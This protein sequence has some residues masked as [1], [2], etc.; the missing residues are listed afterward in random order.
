MIKY[1]Y[2]KF[3]ERVA[4]MKRCKFQNVAICREI[5]EREIF[6]KIF[7]IQHPPIQICDKALYKITNNAGKSFIINSLYCIEYEENRECSVTDFFT[8]MPIFLNNENFS[9]LC[10]L[11]EEECEC[12]EEEVVLEYKV[13]KIPSKKAEH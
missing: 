11:S 13:K 5:K 4:K 8:G 1:K 10:P 7:R 12:S 3:F 2:K 6:R 9:I